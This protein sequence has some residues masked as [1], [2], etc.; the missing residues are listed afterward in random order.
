MSNLDQKLKKMGR[1]ASIALVIIGITL[2]V[3]EVFVHRHGE[4]AM[5][6]LPVFPAVFA[7]VVSVFIVVISIGIRAILSRRED[8]YD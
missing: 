5:E 6:D 1:L 7:F 2:L 4:I 8:Y 3:I